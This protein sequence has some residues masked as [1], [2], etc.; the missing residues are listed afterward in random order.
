MDFLVENNLLNIEEKLI[1]A[2]YNSA[3]SN[4]FNTIRIDHNFP[5][6]GNSI[7]SI[8][9][10][11]YNNTEFYIIFNGWYPDWTL[12][13]LYIK[14][15]EEYKKC[16]NFITSLCSDFLEENEVPEYEFM[17]EWY[18]HIK[19]N[20]ITP[21]NYLNFIQNCYKY[22]IKRATFIGDISLLS[23]FNDEMEFDLEQELKKDVGMF[24]SEAIKA[25][26]VIEKIRSNYDITFFDEKIILR[27]SQIFDLIYYNK[28]IN[29]DINYNYRD[30][31]SYNN[32]DVNNVFFL[33]VMCQPNNYRYLGENAKFY[34]GP[35]VKKEC[36][37]NLG[38]EICDIIVNNNFNLIYL[39]EYYGNLHIFENFDFCDISYKD[40]NFAINFLL[41]NIEY[42][43]DIIHHIFSDI[44]FDVTIQNLRNLLFEYFFFRKF[45]LYVNL[46]T[47]VK[48]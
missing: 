30:L 46:I 11:K 10:T 36:N 43:S 16:Y 22:G 39:Y 34:Y 9:E 26:R 40:N 37:L 31:Y 4:D 25:D 12:Y 13:D 47:V 18:Y 42:R 14:Y 38:Q 24:N 19:T 2:V 23:F 27:Y 5:N 35:Y 3:Y 20:R 33:S 32:I 17:N 8:L 7:R 1:L 21:N 29:S 48:L 15:M 44:K 6:Y 45:R 28:N 41:E